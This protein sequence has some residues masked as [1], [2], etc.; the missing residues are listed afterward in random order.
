M[1][2]G[3]TPPLWSPDLTITLRWPQ[4]LAAVLPAAA[5]EGMG[6]GLCQRRMRALRAAHELGKQSFSTVFATLAH[7]EQEGKERNNMVK[8][9]G[10]LV[11]VS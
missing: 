3:G 10:V 11:L 2:T 1:G 5:D 8:P 4:C 6:A 7:A 9:H